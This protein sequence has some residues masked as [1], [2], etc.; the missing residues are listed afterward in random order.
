MTIE[1]D[2]IGFEFEDEGITPESLQ[3][4]LKLVEK[5]AL[6]RI[7]KE[8]HDIY[9]RLHSINEDV[10]FVD[11]VA[12]NY[13]TLPLVANL[14]CGAWYVNP[15]NS[16]GSQAYFKST[17]G[18]YGNWSFNL[19]RPNLHLLALIVES[20]GMIV[21][22]STRSGKRMPDALSKTLP[23]WCTVVNTAIAQRYNI[24]LSTWDSRLFT[25]PNVVSAQEHAHISG[26][27]D[28]WATALA[29]SSYPLP[30]IPVPLRPIWITPSTTDFPDVSSW[31]EYGLPLVC[32]SA[33]RFVEE[34]LERRAGGYS[35]I[36]GSADDHEMW[37][38]GLTPDLFWANHTAL[39]GCQ[40]DELEAM[41]RQ[42]VLDASFHR[43]KRNPPSAIAK[44]GGRL[45]LCANDDLD[46]ATMGASSSKAYVIIHSTPSP[47][48]SLTF[49]GTGH[50][51]LHVPGG[52]KGSSV[53]RE[54]V[55]PKST[56]F[57]GTALAHGQDVCISCDTGN[58]L[59]AGIVLV[60]LQLFFDDDGSYETGSRRAMG[61][62]QTLQTR[63]EWI[64]SDRP[65][66]N[67]A[68][69]TL[70]RINEFLLSPAR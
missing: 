53:F 44:T 31:N 40:H 45:W 50:L 69:T 3:R 54:D 64:I 38:M 55:L 57:I 29:S 46:A 4:D 9:N 60:C 52:K 7:R 26:K 11:T 34:G 39:L 15:E 22:D 20:K 65:S 66:A 24:E 62:K 2:D 30:R 48:I 68:R 1:P 56:H 51:L 14:R 10:L 19:R 18:H 17:D 21:V 23:I 16:S 58:D 61:N 49:E 63:L 59:A 13:A 6:S 37:A 47:P 33:S 12:K 41:V 43:I 25:P 28:A 35:Y 32:V 36:Q 42:V 27:I 67:P 5:T 70:K 8:S